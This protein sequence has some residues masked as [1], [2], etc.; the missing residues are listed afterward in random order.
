MFQ[1]CYDSLTATDDDDRITLLTN[2]KAQDLA[3]RA[4]ALGWEGLGAVPAWWGEETVWH[5]ILKPETFPRASR[6]AS[7]E[8]ATVTQCLADGNTRSWEKPRMPDLV[9]HFEHFRRLDPDIPFSTRAWDKVAGSLLFA[10]D[11]LA[12]WAK[13][14]A[15]CNARWS[16]LPVSPLTS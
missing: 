10:G 13:P 9:A 7:A 2:P 12:T 5:I 14:C 16:G 4:L 8:A 1:A 11:S 6:S 15:C 3:S